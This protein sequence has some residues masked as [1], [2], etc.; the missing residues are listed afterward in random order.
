M[1]SAIATAVWIAAAAFAQE[2]ASPTTSPTATPTP[3][4]VNSR[5]VR[6][7][8]VPP[9]MEGTISLGIF[10]SNRK[11]VRVL[12]REAKIENFQIDETSLSTSWDGKSDDGEDLPP[13][14]YHARGYL[15][16]HLAI[17]EISPTG[18]LPAA[19]AESD[20]IAVKLTTNP[21]LNDARSVVDLG[22][23]FDASGSFLRTTDNL[24][25]YTVSRA[26][27]LIR[28]SIQKDDEKSV[29]GWQDDGT[30]IRQFHV[31]DIDKMMSFD[32]GEI[33][34]K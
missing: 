9:P 22:V 20:H 21:L 12:H 34:L 23:G 2:P 24:P 33:Q 32:C 14:R 29:A 17:Q 5:S 7:S 13:G 30:S 6:I 25:L 28:V 1:K 27:N 15:V 4:P 18:S 3:T 11:L 8:F 16:R 19:D 31:T 26:S 10:D